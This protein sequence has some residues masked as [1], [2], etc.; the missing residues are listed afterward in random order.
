MVALVPFRETRLTVLGG[1]TRTRSSLT[2]ANTS[3]PIM[4]WVVTAE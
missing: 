4:A 1:L 3:S 2:L